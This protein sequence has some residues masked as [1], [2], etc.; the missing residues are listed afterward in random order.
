MHSGC[1]TV[2]VLQAPKESPVN[3]GK[4]VGEYQTIN[5]TRG[6]QEAGSVYNQ[7]FFWS[8]YGLGVGCNVSPR[9]AKAI[10]MEGNSH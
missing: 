2:I 6:G 10:G 3:T 8:V 9:L 1:S 4:Q 5:T 7:H